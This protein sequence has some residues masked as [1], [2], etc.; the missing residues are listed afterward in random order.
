MKIFKEILI[1]LFLVL[2]Y[3]FTYSQEDNRIS[4]KKTYFFAGAGYA[5]TNKSTSGYSHIF[6]DGFN[7]NAKSLY[8]LNNSFGFRADFDFYHFKRDQ[9][10]Y[11]T[12]DFA[13]VS[14][15]YKYFGGDANAFVIRENLVIGSLNPD[16]PVEF[17]FLPAIGIGLSHNTATYDTYMGSGYG[18]VYAK[19]DVAHNLF[20]IGISFGAGFNVKLARNTRVFAE[21]QYDFWY[22]G[23]DGPPPFSAVKFGIIL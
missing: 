3:N 22:M 5:I 8:I 21:Y 23:G 15:T 12:S 11:K 2:C 10:S 9:Y 6:F 19:S 4:V 17:Y 20:C 16:Q 14:R 7:I 1:I 18:P 13:G